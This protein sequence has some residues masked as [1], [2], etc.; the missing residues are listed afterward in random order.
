MS[1]GMTTAPNPTLIYIGTVLSDAIENVFIGNAIYSKIE[2]H[3]LGNNGAHIKVYFPN[4]GSEVNAD[5]AGICQIIQTSNSTFG[6]VLFSTMHDFLT[7]ATQTIVRQSEDT[8][9]LQPTGG[10][11]DFRVY[12]YKK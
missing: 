4:S 2:I 11:C 3:A 5:D 12:A 7:G 9:Q 8:I 1:S 6:D 10:D